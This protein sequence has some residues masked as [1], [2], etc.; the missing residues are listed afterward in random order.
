[1]P[2]Q[3][4]WGSVVDAFARHRYRKC[5][6]DPDGRMVRRNV[7][8]RASRTHGLG[9]EAYRIEAGRALG[10]AAGGSRAKR[11]VNIRQRIL[12]MGRA[13]AQRL[14]I[15]WATATRWKRRLR[16]GNVLTNGHGGRALDRVRA[17]LT[18]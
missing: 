1:M 14:D 16:S 2:R 13:E 12:E 4:T 8:V 15:P 17:I 3:R 9:K 7:L 5:T 11:Y 18:V 6:L 10:Y